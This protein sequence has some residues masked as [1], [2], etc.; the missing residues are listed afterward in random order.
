MQPP[1]DCRTLA[2]IRI[3][4]DRIDRD[5]IRAIGARKHYV[6]AAAALKS[7]PAEVAAPERFAAMLRARRQWAEDEGLSPT[8]IENL[9]RDL[10]NHFI[11]E[12]HE[13]WSRRPMPG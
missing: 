2:D 12:E 5:I 6:V 13:H 3:E 1:E 10:I 9:F 8:V 4:I 7:N 11:T